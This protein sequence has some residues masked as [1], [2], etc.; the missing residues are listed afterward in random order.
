M[1]ENS[2]FFILQ[3]RVIIDT[4]EYIFIGDEECDIEIYDEVGAALSELYREPQ[5]VV[6]EINTNNSMED[7]WH[8][9]QKLR[10]VLPDFISLV[11]FNEEVEQLKEKAVTR[12]K[13]IKL[14]KKDSF[15]LDNL[16]NE[17]ST[18]IKKQTVHYQM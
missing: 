15:F 6:Y 17:I 7:E 5:I 3:S 13:P 4:I 9:V 10:A 12:A 14:V 2:I 11:V 8:E 1:K 16:F 18:E